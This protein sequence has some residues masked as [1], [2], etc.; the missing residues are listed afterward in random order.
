MEATMELKVTYTHF[1]ITKISIF[2]DLETDLKNCLAKFGFE[3]T[4]ADFDFETGERNLNFINEE[5]SSKFE[6]D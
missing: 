6:D 5:W 1:D 2:D 4:D 3:R